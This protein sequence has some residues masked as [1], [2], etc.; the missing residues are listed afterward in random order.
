MDDS[1]KRWHYFPVKEKHCQKGQE[2]ERGRLG[3]GTKPNA[4]LLTTRRPGYRPRNLELLLN[5]LQFSRRGPEV[6]AV[7][8]SGSVRQCGGAR[9]HLQVSTEMG[10]SVLWWRRQPCVEIMVLAVDIL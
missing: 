4:A 6:T 3:D 9:L 10:P 2:V 7:R 5:C 8:E 1:I